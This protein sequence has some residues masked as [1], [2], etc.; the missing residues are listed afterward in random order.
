VAERLPLFVRYELRAVAS[1]TLKA[2]A[3]S[4]AAAQNAL[5]DCCFVYECVVK[6]SLRIA[7]TRWRCSC[8]VIRPVVP[9]P[10]RSEPP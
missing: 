8:Q 5:D 7:T 1:A 9:R 3:E 2:E 10:F 4:K 6:Q